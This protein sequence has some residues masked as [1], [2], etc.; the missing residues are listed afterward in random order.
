MYP[1]YT[2]SWYIQMIVTK[3]TDAANS[4]ISVYSGFICQQIVNGNYSICTVFRSVESG[5]NEL[6]SD[7]DGLI[8]F[9]VANRVRYSNDIRFSNCLVLS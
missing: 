8:H 1:E 9:P 6:T 3:L 4:V 5:I 2:Y 7:S